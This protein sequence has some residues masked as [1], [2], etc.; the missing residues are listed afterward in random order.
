MFAIIVSDGSVEPC[1]FRCVVRGVVGLKMIEFKRRH[2][3]EKINSTT[4]YGRKLTLVQQLKMLENPSLDL[5]FTTYSVWGTFPSP[6]PIPACS[7][8]F[9]LG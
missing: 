9:R 6:C 8:T 2:V 3:L 4:D 7:Q 5:F 1:A